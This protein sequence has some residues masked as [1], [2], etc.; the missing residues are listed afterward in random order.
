MLITTAVWG[1][2]HTDIHLNVN[3]PTLLAEGNLPALADDF[4]VRYRIY[5]RKEDYE[6][7]D[8]HPAVEALRDAH[9]QVEFEL[10]PPEILKDPIAAH[11]FAWNEATKSAKERGEYLLLMPPDVAWAGRSFVSVAERVKRGE[12]AVFMTYLRTDDAGFLPEIRARRGD[13]LILD[14]SQEDMVGICMRHLHPLMA[15][16]FRDSDFFPIHPEMILWPVPGEGVAVRVL[17]REMFLFDPSWFDLNKAALPDRRFEPGEASFIT[18]SD[19]LFAVSFAEVGKDVQW[20]ILPKRAEPM[21]IAP[22]WLTYDS[23]SNDF[24]AAQKIRWHFKPVTERAWRQVEAGADLWVRRIAAVREGLRIWQVAQTRGCRKAGEVLS[25]LI[26]TGAVA[27]AI[28]RRDDAIIFLPR[29]AAFGSEN[30]ERVEQALE[31][32]D[33]KTLVEVAR[34]QIISMPGAWSGSQ[35]PLD[36]ALDDAASRQL[37]VD[38]RSM[39]LVRMSDGTIRIN[40]IKILS[41]PIRAGSSVVYVVEELFA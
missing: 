34:H 12:K 26:N 10:M 21:E 38:G 29:D 36:M 23:R 14:V 37:A 35:D 2:W 18:D 31:E 4:R 27:R 9:I 17:A 22:W 7:L 15:A 39:R 5:T 6:T 13:D 20:H 32:C 1:A 41:K 8:F 30:G 40:D 3:L 11:H 19:E 33:V 24:M 25:V 16:S 28:G